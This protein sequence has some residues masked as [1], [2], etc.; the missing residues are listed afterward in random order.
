MTTVK[1]ILSENYKVIEAA[2]GK[3]GIEMA[4]KHRPHLILMDIELPVL[5]GI[6]AFITIRNNPLLQHVPII[7]L[8]ASAMTDDREAILAHGFDA[9][10]AKP[11]DQSVFFKTINEVLYGK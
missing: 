11:I 1:A 6:S 9:Y 2:D 10:L 8:T 3:A 5:D 7:A 4:K